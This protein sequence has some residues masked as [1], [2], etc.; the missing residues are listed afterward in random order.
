MRLFL[1]II[2]GAGLVIG[3]AYLHDSSLNGPFQAQERLVNWNVADR[4]AQDAYDSARAQIERW[5]GY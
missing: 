5:T 1:G 3:G 4:I 2:I